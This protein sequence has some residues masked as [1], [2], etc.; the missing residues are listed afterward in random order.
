[1]RVSGGLM[2]AMARPFRARPRPLRAAALVALALLAALA[3][4][5]AEIFVTYP[6]RRNADAG[7]DGATGGGFSALTGGGGGGARARAL[8]A[9]EGNVTTTPLATALAQPNPGVDYWG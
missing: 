3:P 9:F 4:A 1:M 7:E 6:T 5:Y 8:S 2:R